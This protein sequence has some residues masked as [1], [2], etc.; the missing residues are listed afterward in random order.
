MHGGELIAEVLKAHGVKFLFTLCGGHISPILVGCKQLG[1]QVIDVRHEATAVFA[2][3]AVSRL[4]GVPGVAAV[5]AGPGAT[6][7][8]TA[9]KNAQLA[10]SPVILLGGATATALKGRGSLQDIDQMALFKPHVKWARSVQKVRE[11]APA[12]TQAFREAQK[13]VPGPVFVECPIDLLYSE[14]LVREWYGVQSKKSGRQTVADR[15]LN[16]YLKQHVTRLFSGANKIRIPKPQA[17]SVPAPGRARIS[18]VAEKLRTAQKPLLL[19]GSQALLHKN[20]LQ[21]VV[22]A[23]TQLQIPVYLSGMARGLLGVQHPLQ[24]RHQRRLALKEADLVLLAGVPCD[25]RLNYGRHIPRATQLISVNLSRH[26]LMLNR[27]PSIAIQGEP[28]LFLVQL[29]E[30]VKHANDCRDWLNTL[31]QRDDT[32]ETEIQQKACEPTERVNPLHLCGEIERVLTENSIL[33]ADGGDFVAT[34]SYIVQPRAPLSWLDP[35]VFGTLGVGAGFALGAKLC[36]PDADVWILFGDGSLGYSLCEF[37]TFVRHEIP[38]LAIVG[39][40]AGWSQIAREQ[41]EIFQDEVGTVLQHSNYHL[42]AEALGGKG[43]LVR[44]AA[45]ITGALRLAKSALARGK[46]VLLNA[47]L[48]KTDFRKGSISM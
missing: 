8:V 7:T 28:G 4:S 22:S 11:L 48:S 1:I 16:L 41:V 26:D 23:V 29:A 38:V 20:Q 5:T 27:R 39:N 3:D 14:D 30:V 21:A 10:Q 44:K 35:G 13:G 19:I 17:V 36:R 34:A 31:R 47:H 2:A 25:F 9:V 40:D 42:M 43:L 24:L 33:V 32:R 45:E 18:R 15:A 6:N 37:D 12:V 46:V